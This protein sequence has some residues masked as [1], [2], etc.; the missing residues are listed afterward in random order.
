[1]VDRQAIF[2]LPLVNHLVEQRLEG[3][4]PAMTPEMPARDGDL[5]TLTTGRGAVMSEPTPHPARYA[6]RNRFQIAAEMFGVEALVPLTELERERFVVGVSLLAPSALW[7]RL[8]LEGDDPLTGRAPRGARSALDESHDRLVHLDRRG[9]IALVHAKTLA[10]KA[11][12]HVSVSREAAIVDSPQSQRSKSDEQLDGV[13]WRR[14]R[15][16][17]ERELRRI[18]AARENRGQRAKHFTGPAMNVR[19]SFDHTNVDTSM[20]CSLMRMLLTDDG[21]PPRDRLLIVP[22]VE[23]IV[24]RFVCSM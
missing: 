11:H 22:D 6:Y 3:L 9:E 4:G 5:S 23:M 19:S 8:H 16:E 7:R 24:P 14:G 1:M 17:I 18:A 10:L 2:I 15:R 20:S 13:A 12:H 21:R